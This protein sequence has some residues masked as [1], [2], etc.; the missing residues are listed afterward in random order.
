MQYSM[1]DKQQSHYSSHMQGRQEWSPQHCGHHI[2]TTVY[3][4][5]M[6]SNSSFTW[7]LLVKQR[8]WIYMYRWR[9]MN[10]LC[11]NSIVSL[12]WGDNVV[13]RRV[14]VWDE[15]CWDN[16]ASRVCP[17]V[18]WW[19]RVVSGLVTLWT[20]F[21]KCTVC[22]CTTYNMIHGISNNSWWYMYAMSQVVPEIIWL[23]S[24]VNALITFTTYTSIN[25]RYWLLL[26]TG[27]NRFQ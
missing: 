27:N 25:I 1:D 17:R 6:Y 5:H 9:A 8:V 11:K 15:R 20:I 4:S 19:V 13:G 2:H 10:K 24:S 26:D 16:P 7:W 22:L 21:T 18:M 3:K 12:I 14:S 23:S